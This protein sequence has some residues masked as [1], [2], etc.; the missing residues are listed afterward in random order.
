MHKLFLALFMTLAVSVCAHAKPLIFV[1]DVDFA[2]YSM[3]TDGQPAGIDVEV[4]REAAKRAG[5]EVEIQL[6]PWETLV[7]MIEKGTCDG[8]FALFHN[9]QRDKQLLFME[10][11]PIH[12][13]NY[14]LFTTSGNKFSFST[15]DDLTGK[16]I[17]RVAGTDLGKEMYEAHQA[18][19]LTIKDYPDLASALRGLLLG[20]VEAYAGNIDVTYHRLKEMGMTSSIVYLPKKL[21]AMRP[22]FMVMSRA[23]QTPDKELI[24]QKL[25]QSLDNMRKDGV[26]NKIARKYL[27]RF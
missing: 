22:A 9:P 14:V 20:E 25:Q 19:K 5:L 17:G 6:K 3:L 13:S 1:T 16:S 24:I 4:F 7:E 26:Y 21:V 27:L 23:A 12:Y 10:K 8:A 2:P 11:T 15:Y 18:G